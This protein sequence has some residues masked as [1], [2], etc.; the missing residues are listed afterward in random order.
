LKSRL[1]VLLALL[2][3]A[4]VFASPALAVPPVATFT[5]PAF[6]E[7]VS[8]PI[9]VNVVTDIPVDSV[10]LRDAGNVPLGSFTDVGGATSWSI[11]VDLSTYA[12]QEGFILQALATVGGEFDNADITFELDFDLPP[13]VTWVS[14]VSANMRTAE[15]LQITT[16]GTETNVKFYFRNVLQMGTITEAPA[17]TYTMAFD[18]DD[19]ANGTGDLRADVTNA[20]G[21]TQEIY[22]VNI[23]NQS[24]DPGWNAPGVD[25]QEIGISSGLLLQAGTSTEYDGV[26]FF[27]DGDPI[28]QA[29]EEGG[30]DTNDWR[31]QFDTSGS[32]LGAH[33]LTAVSQNG[34]LFSAGNDIN[35]VFVDDID[36]TVATYSPVADSDVTGGVFDFSITTSDNV[37]ATVAAYS[38]DG[39]TFFPMISE[40]A[41]VF[42][43]DDLDV[44]ALPYGQHFFYVEIEDA[45]GN[46]A[47]G[48][49]SLNILN[50]QAP[51]LDLDDLEHFGSLQVGGGGY[52][53]FDATYDDGYPGPTVTYSWNVCD[54]A[55]CTVRVGQ[56]YTPIEAEIGRTVELIITATNS[57]GTDA[58]SEMIAGVVTAADPDVAPD[59]PQ[60]S[61][62][63]VVVPPVVTPPVAEKTPE[64]VAAEQKVVV[65][66]QVVVV[67]QQKVV[68]A[69]EKLVAEREDVQDAKK[70]A[71]KQ[72]AA[73]EKLADLK[74]ELRADRKP[75][76]AIDKKIKAA[77]KK[78]IAAQKAVA[79]D[80]AEAAAQRK[81]ADAAKAAASAAAKR[82]HAARV[83]LEDA[84]TG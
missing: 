59:G 58:Y 24:D 14:P 70:A 1:Y 20:N 53:A 12:D 10:D 7:V 27:L 78:A 41:G 34:T 17:N 25:G 8:G 45:E 61:P 66:E 73:V 67:A 3:V 81:K 77:Q 42:S 33:V 56:T 23:D 40:G 79:T 13:D 39:S 35:V 54:G 31:F 47:A 9:T 50:P 71:I 29:V 26:E 48:N 22:G 37:L 2:S 4:A 57:A 55:T 18:P 84:R 51:T 19:H 62:E 6:G 36:P 72:R 65:A 68:V 5:S 46:S 44:S 69:V 83:A 75:T 82:A 28:G 63:P 11:V 15:D 16:D 64:V 21:T 38:L 76:A 30:L 80:A 43:V 74:R 60:S 32:T 52:Q 49:V